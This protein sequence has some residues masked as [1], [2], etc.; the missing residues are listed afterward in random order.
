MLHLFKADYPIYSLISLD[1]FY[2]VL[3]PEVDFFSLLLSFKFLA[4]RNP[5][6]CTVNAATITVVTY[7]TA[8]SLC[9]RLK[10]VINP[11]TRITA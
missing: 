7:I 2:F 8:A 9:A 10:L 6:A 11:A 4:Y 1:I 5:I 3:A